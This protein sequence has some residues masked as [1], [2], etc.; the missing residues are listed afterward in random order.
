MSLPA[1]IDP[2]K[3]ALK[4]LLLRVKLRLGSN[5]VERLS[6]AISGALKDC[7]VAR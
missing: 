5:A 2:R 7:S 4:E 3:L 6:E 1:E